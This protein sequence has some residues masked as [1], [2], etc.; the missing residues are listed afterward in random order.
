VKAGSSYL[1]QSD[2]RVHFGMEHAPRADRLEIRWPSGA[3][4]VL[5]NLEANQILTV[6]EGQGITARTSL[7]R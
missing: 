2:I 4:E 6:T 1:S 5:Q 7:R 3:T